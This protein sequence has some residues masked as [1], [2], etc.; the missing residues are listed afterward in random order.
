MDVCV[1][2]GAH[3]SWGA[4]VLGHTPFVLGPGEHGMM[5]LLGHVRMCINMH[6]C[7]SVSSLS[8][9]CVC[10]RCGPDALLC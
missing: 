7:W 3:L 5:P 10:L 6:M 4:F 2:A 1:C 8:T 9:S